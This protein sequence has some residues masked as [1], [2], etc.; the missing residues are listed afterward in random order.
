MINLFS[1][2]L[3]EFEIPQHVE[4]NYK[5][6]SISRNVEGE[7]RYFETDHPAVQELK[8][9]MQGYV[10]DISKE[11]G[12]REL[13]LKGRQNVIMPGECDGPH[14]HPW[15]A[16]TAV[17]YVEVPKNSGDILLHDPRGGINYSWWPYNERRRPFIRI[18]PKAGMLLIF[19]GYLVH[20]VETNLSRSPRISIVIDAEGSPIF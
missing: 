8:N 17:Y 14:N 6:I 2:P 18:T 11:Y 19:P 16:V 7:H 1:T 9:K 13:T 4:L 20:S 10:N 3:W 15:S 12:W 5:L